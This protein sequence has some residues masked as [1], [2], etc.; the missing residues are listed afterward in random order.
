MSE[1][2]EPQ[3]TLFSGLLRNLR[4]EKLQK[5]VESLSLPIKTGSKL[6][7]IDILVAKINAHFKGHPDLYE[8]PQYQGLVAYRKPSVGGANTVKK[9]SVD[10]QAA[11]AGQAA[12]R[13][14]AK[15]AAKT[16]NEMGTTVDP[17]AHRRPV[18]NLSSIPIDLEP[19]DSEVPQTPKKKS[20]K[21][22]KTMV[23]D[24]QDGRL[25]VWVHKFG[26]HGQD[27]PVAI[28]P[29]P[30]DM[31]TIICQHEGGNPNAPM[32]YVARLLQILP[33][34]FEEN[35]PIKAHSSS[36]IYH[37]VKDANVYLGSVEKILQHES[38]NFKMLFL[39]HYVL[40]TTTVPGSFICH[41]WCD[42]MEASVHELEN[43]VPNVADPGS[44][45]APSTQATHLDPPHLHSKQ[46]TNY[47]FNNLRGS[48]GGFKI[49]ED[50]TATKVDEDDRDHFDPK[51]LLRYPKIADWLKDPKDSQYSEKFNNMTASQFDVY[52]ARKS[53]GEV[54]ALLSRESGPSK[55]ELRTVDDD[56]S[57]EEVQPAS[58]KME[59]M[60]IALVKIYLLQLL[61]VIHW[62][63]GGTFKEENCSSFCY[64]SSI[65]DTIGQEKCSSLYPEK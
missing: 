14:E 23:F 2:A 39:D 36:K 6:D 19:L 31:Y 24:N 17:P 45:S 1:P 33:N 20:N 51:T 7:T 64:G 43:A 18:S 22:V 16:L 9:N 38:R 10:K 60:K 8:Q 41:I 40:D 47:H 56:D 15:G 44:A 5:L 50:I 32:E 52:K 63:H 30:A 26:G 53:G 55:E 21:V 42:N 57:E 34:A 13:L 37:R 46:P 62:A 59:G 4:K 25:I 3:A 29:M 35:S 65:G 28:Y 11:D 27:S 54:K 48:E 12:Q 61:L 49:P 58:K